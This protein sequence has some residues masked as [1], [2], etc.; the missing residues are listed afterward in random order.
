MDPE[1]RGVENR[2]M[3]WR[4]DPYLVS[5]DPALLDLDVIHAELARSYWAEGI[6][7]AVVERSLANS[8]CFGLHLREAQIGF[9]R[10]ITD[11]ATFAYVA[12]VF[13][14]A[15]HRGLGLGRWLVECVRA[16]PD[17][18]GLRRLVLVT[19]DAHALYAKTGWKPL[20]S[21]ERYME[22][23]RKDPYLHGGSPPAIPPG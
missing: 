20:E 3:E 2:G 12:D 1:P 8:L 21:P 18:R 13:V 23:V 5:D 14:L 11:R 17:L 22:I 10:A 9:A 15:E 7:R 6:P 4:R 19:R 16:H